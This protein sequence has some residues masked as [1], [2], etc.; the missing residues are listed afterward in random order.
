MSRPNIENE[1]LLTLDYLKQLLNYD[2]LTGIF[3]WVVSRNRRVKIGQ[4]AG[5]LNSPIL[6]RRIEIDGKSY[7]AHRLA[8]LYVYGYF[9]CGVVD[10]IDGNPS[11]NKI[12]NLRECTQ[13]E[14]SRNTN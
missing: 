11:N 14:N 12:T 7:G 13:G 1:S 5:Y 3:T 2:P 9:P 10:H 6:H 8:W 4:I